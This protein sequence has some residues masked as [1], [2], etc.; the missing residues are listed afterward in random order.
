MS[1]L[2]NSIRM[3]AMSSAHRCAVASS[4][5]QG[6]LTGGILGTFFSRISTDA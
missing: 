1:T 4:A 2:A 5:G 3:P 6:T